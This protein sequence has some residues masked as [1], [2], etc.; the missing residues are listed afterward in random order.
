ML[1]EAEITITT[2][3][4]LLRMSLLYDREVN[5]IIRTP[6][7]SKCYYFTTCVLIP[8]ISSFLSLI[9]WNSVDNADRWT[10]N[11]NYLAYCHAVKYGQDKLHSLKINTRFQQHHF[12][13]YKKNMS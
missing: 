4:L 13:K 3:L 7:V 5:A 12:L 1:S 2:A 6:I 8:W 10:M 11:H 9:G